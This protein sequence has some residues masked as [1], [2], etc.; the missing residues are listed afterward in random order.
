MSL[1][2]GMSE[3]WLRRRGTRRPLERMFG[4][5]NIATLRE[6]A[7]L[8]RDLRTLLPETRTGDDVVV[9]VH[10]LMATA[11]V[12]RPLRAELERS[13]GARVASFTYVSGMRV[14]VV[15]HKLAEL[16]GRISSG[17][18]IHL[19]GHSLGGVVARHFVQELGGH[20]R[21]VQTVSLGSPFWGVAK[22]ERFAVGVGADLRLSSEVLVRLRA[23]VDVGGVPHTSIVGGD[24]RVV[25]EPWRAM[26]AGGDVFVFAGLGHNG[27]LFDEEAA[28]IVVERIRR[29][30]VTRRA[31]TRPEP[32]RALPPAFVLSTA[33]SM[34]EARSLAV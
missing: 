5:E 1:H 3:V 26:L 17:T 16:V 19:V 18:R 25:G 6:A 23:R 24:D 8:P 31:S 10:G 15:A 2:Q 28:H 30:P 27:L 29:P 22:A 9:L 21:V 7:L 34:F 33:R 20:T 11:G 12:F 4:A 32:T 14:N 13:T